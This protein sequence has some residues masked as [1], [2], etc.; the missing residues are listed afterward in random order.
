MDRRGVGLLVVLAGVALGAAPQQ[1]RGDALGDPLPP[2]VLAR[3]G[4]RR[5]ARGGAV[6]AFFPDGRRVALASHEMTP[7][8]EGKRSDWRYVVRVYDVRSGNALQRL[9]GDDPRIPAHL[10]CSADGKRIVSLDEGG[11]RVWNATS[12]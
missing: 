9:E 5:M 10:A 2:G 7:L 11:V 3:L 4:T 12:G 6:I 1:P 8:D